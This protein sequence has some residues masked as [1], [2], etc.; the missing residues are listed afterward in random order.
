[1]N[2]SNLTVTTSFGTCIYMESNIG[3]GVTIQAYVALGSRSSSSWQGDSAL[4][5]STNT[6]KLGQVSHLL[7]GH[8]A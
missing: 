7:V 4:S 5:L 8:P 1:M 3:R 2:K 6:D